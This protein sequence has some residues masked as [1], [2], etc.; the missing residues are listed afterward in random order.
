M[1]LYLYEGCVA[2]GVLSVWGA[3]LFSSPLTHHGRKMLKKGV[4]KDF[5]VLFYLFALAYSAL[6]FSIRGRA[7]RCFLALFAHLLRRAVESTVYTYTYHSRM[8]I[9]QLGLGFFYYFL[10]VT[11]SFYVH[12]QLMPRLFLLASAAQMVSHYFLFRH[13]VFTGYTHYLTEFLIHLSLSRDP[14]NLLWIASFALL[15]V[16]NRAAFAG[17]EQASGRVPA[18]AAARL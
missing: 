15:T 17:T 12:T 10:L 2:L 18:N 1:F 5:F 16:S 9:H 11:R 4:H 14:L 3:Y 6:L 7:P 13:R 8:G